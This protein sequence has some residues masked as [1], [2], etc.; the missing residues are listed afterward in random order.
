MQDFQS[1]LAVVSSCGKLTWS[2]VG[3]ERRLL[4]L[5]PHYF[6]GCLTSPDEATSYQRDVLSE[7]LQ[8]FKEHGPM[9]S[10]KSHSGVS[11]VHHDHVP[12]SQEAAGR[13]L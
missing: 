9:S 5:A 10:V 11:H 3:E 2:E 8:L 12:L 4:Q 1:P 6:L 7:L 13:A